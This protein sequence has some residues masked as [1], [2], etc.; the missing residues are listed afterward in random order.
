MMS[1]FLRIADDVECIDVRPDLRV[2]VCPR[3]PAL[4]LPGSEWSKLLDA[5]GNGIPRQ[6]LEERLAGTLSP[7]RAAVM[8][9]YL[10]R[11][12]LLIESSTANAVGIYGMVAP[13][14]DR[15]TVQLH[16]FGQTDVRTYRTALTFAGLREEEGAAMH[17]VLT[18]DYLLPELARFNVD[19]LADRQPWLLAA[20]GGSEA[21]VGPLFI[22]GSGPC[23]GCLESR[24][25]HRHQTRRF[26]G[27]FQGKPMTIGPR[28]SSS[29]TRATSMAMLATIVERFFATGEHLPFSQHV[30]SINFAYGTT[31]D[32]RLIRRTQCPQCGDTR[33]AMPKPANP[34]IRVESPPATG[35]DR[36]EVEPLVTFERF[37]HHISPVT[38]IADALVEAHPDETILCYGV[39]KAD[40]RRLLSVYDLFAQRTLLQTG[41]GWGRGL[42]HAQARVGALCETIER[43]TLMD[44]RPPDH[45]RASLDG[46]NGVAIDP[47]KVLLFSDSQYG[48]LGSGFGHNRI[49]DQRFDPT[50]TI[51]WTAAWSMT[52]DEERLVASDQM[53]LT[54][55]DTRDADFC[56]AD[57]NGC[58]A[59]N[60]REEAVLRGLLELIERDGIAIWWYNQLLVPAVDLDV[61][62]IADLSDLRRH[63]AQ[64]YDRDLW[65]LDVTTDLG[66]PVYAAVSARRGTDHPEYV[67]CFGCHLDPV[68]AVQSAVTELGMMMAS[69]RQFLTPPGH[70]K[71]S[72]SDQANC[73]DHV[74][75]W[76]QETTIE[77]QPQMRPAKGVP[78][79]AIKSSTLGRR[80]VRDDLK[81]CMERLTHAGIEVVVVDATRPD[82]GLP[83]VRVLAPGL[84]HFRPRFAPGRLYDVPVTRGFRDQPLDEAELNPIPL[85]F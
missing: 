65:V 39:I 73:P 71:W 64:R 33:A 80:N 20:V 1:P 66:V 6:Q 54:S 35:E 49:P 81:F 83:V 62:G 43:F 75:Q 69:W 76:L 50:R 44:E 77:E 46:L 53:W 60:T 58:A 16:A 79:R 63:Y 25:R 29:A 12:S 36:A 19:R 37:S 38:G 57:S 21:W 2:L 85:A 4:S 26:L 68:A 42:R 55:L 17:V 74:R 84:R 9:E 10:R 13:L 78:Q 56:I 14:P 47:R 52:F 41:V 45:C 7:S 51:G 70:S 28:P 18:D 11:R 59:G 61:D 3:E 82:I 15:A 40:A 31:A 48:Q 27:Q 8:I 23:W 67:A 30:R 24:H 5:I 22:P 72:G 34:L 32:H